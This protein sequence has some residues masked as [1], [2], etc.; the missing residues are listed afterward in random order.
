MQPVE[1]LK[2]YWGY[3]SFRPLQDKIIASVLNGNDTLALLPTGGGKSICFQV[4]AL[5]LDGICIVVSPLIA[6]MKDQV[7][8]LNKRGIKAIAIYSGIT[9]NELDV[10]LDN[11]VYGNIKFLYLSPE[12]LMNDMVQ[13][14]IQKMKVNL[15]AVDEAH[16]ISQWGYDFR[17][18]YLTIADIRELHPNV[19]VLALTASATNEVANDIQD[20]LLFRKKNIFRLSF[21]RKNL[22]YVVLLEDDKNKK[23]L[24][25]LQKV[26]GTAI[27]Y[28]R[29][30]RKTQEIADFLIQNN[31]TADYYH[32][33]L[34]AAQ[35]NAKQESWINNSR[36][37]IVATNAFGMGI[38]KPNVRSV[39]HVDLPDNLEAYYQEAGRGG[40]DEKT[41]YAVILYN[42]NDIAELQKRTDQN[43]PPLSQIRLVYKAI[44]NFL[45]IPLDGGAGIS[46]DFDLAAFART[47]DFNAFMV[48]ACLKMLELENMLSL[49]ESFYIP[50]R[51]KIIMSHNDFYNFQVLNPEFDILIKTLLR[52]YE[53]LYDNYVNINESEIAKRAGKPIDDV[54]KSLYRLKQINVIEY[55]PQTDKPQ[56]LFLQERIPEKNI[57]LSTEVYAR[58]KERFKKRLESMVNYVTNEHQCRSVMLLNYFNEEQLYRCGICDYCRRRNK[59]EMND[60]EYESLLTDVKHY[61][62][63]KPSSLH[64]LLALLNRNNEEKSLHAIQWMIDNE[65]IVYDNSNHLRLKN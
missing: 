29:N 38:D 12:R 35:R 4:P 2:K 16:C 58:R 3:D 17:P 44:C 62:S 63:I 59:L 18:P 53:G 50:S 27:I 15:F 33:G 37:V 9:Y 26:A 25:I 5:C 20:K 51:V 22:N 10:A 7:E 55:L 52:S 47:Y 24:D 48:M 21:E 39:I 32:A 11:C 8:N 49:S 57:E 31:I 40:R 64:E 54:F 42:H 60:V 65:L 43:F 36:R 41:A 46:Y 14:R 45:Q 28:V 30:R 6:L 19:P 23:L 13:M 1:V 34:P 56:L 61:L